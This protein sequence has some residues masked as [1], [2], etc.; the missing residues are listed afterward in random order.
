MERRSPSLSGMRTS[1]RSLSIL[2]GSLSSLATCGRVPSESS[3]PQRVRKGTSVLRRVV[4]VSVCVLAIAACSGSDSGSDGGSKGASSTVTGATSLEGGTS[5]VPLVTQT[6][7]MP[8]CAQMPTTAD[9]SAA[10]GVPLSDGLVTASGT[11]QYQGLNDQSKVLTLSLYT[12]PVD[13]TAFTDLQSS[14]GT[15]TP[16]ADSPVSGAIVGPDSS[17]YVT[18]NNAVYVVLTQVTG[19]SAADQ[20]PLSV[21]VLQKWLAI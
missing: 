17:V 20:V 19:A 5:P 11:C 14:L 6:T 13:Q 10:V 21:A 12:D 16:L 1:T 15:G 9:L 7:F 18:V 3:P 4:L 2:I 8:T